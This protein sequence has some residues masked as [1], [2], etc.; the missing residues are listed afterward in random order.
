MGCGGSKS[1]DI[2]SSSEARA[3]SPAVE[4]TK[5]LE[6]DTDGIT[7]VEIEEEK[8][9]PLT[10]EEASNQDEKEKLSPQDEPVLIKEEIV[11]I[12]RIDEEEEDDKAGIEG[13]SQN[14]F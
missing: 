5:P 11:Q 8:S 10:S 13:K 9:F 1:I 14:W 4:I 12:E 2:S 7:T 3:P 6:A